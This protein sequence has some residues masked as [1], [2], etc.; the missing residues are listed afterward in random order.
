MY[1]TVYFLSNKNHVKQ[2]STKTTKN[3][4]NISDAFLHAYKH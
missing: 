2:Q 1:Q 4:F 3:S